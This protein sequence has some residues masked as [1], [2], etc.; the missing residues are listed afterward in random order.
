MQAYQD[1]RTR[2]EAAYKQ[3]A[4]SLAAGD[5]AAQRRPT[6]PAAK[7]AP[8]EDPQPPAAARVS[9]TLSRE[10]GDGDATMTLRADPCRKV[11]LD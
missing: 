4:S 6:Q 8:S 3:L 9:Q 5:V 1:E 10:S 2:L 11:A 7:A